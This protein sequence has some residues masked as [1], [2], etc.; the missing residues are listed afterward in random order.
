MIFI[1]TP[2][3]Y[4][5]A[6][7]YIKNDKFTMLFLLIITIGFFNQIDFMNNELS[8]FNGISQSIIV[9]HIMYQEKYIYK[10]YNDTVIKYNNKIE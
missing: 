7:D 5:M 4:K 1:H 8:V 6:W 10:D 2:N 9:S 3:H